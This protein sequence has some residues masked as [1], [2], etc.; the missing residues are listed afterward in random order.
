MGDLRGSRVWGSRGS[1]A[2]DFGSG[3]VHTTLGIYTLGIYSLGVYSLGL[4][5]LDL[6]LYIPVTTL[7]VCTLGVYTLGVYSLG[8]PILDLD[9]HLPHSGALH[10]GGLHFGGL[11][12]RATDFGSGTAL[13]CS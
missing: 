10:S 13:T 5:I 2:T 12:S 7:G 11:L 1:R 8:L 9:P 6:E 4:P 3:T